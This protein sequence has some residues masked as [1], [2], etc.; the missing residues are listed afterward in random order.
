MLSN[1]YAN[2]PSNPTT[3]SSSDAPFP[4]HTGT[5]TGTSFER[6]TDLLGLRAY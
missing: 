2:L 4:H 6:L 1:N 5:N 3:L